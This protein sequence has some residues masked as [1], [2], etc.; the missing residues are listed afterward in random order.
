[1]MMLLKNRPTPP[2]AC[3]IFFVLESDFS[4][5][6]QS[7]KILSASTRTS[8]LQETAVAVTLQ[9]IQKQIHSITSIRLCPSRHLIPERLYFV[10]TPL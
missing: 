6:E 1:M 5:G 7:R 3:R 10:Q 4:S 9:A 8:E 2:H